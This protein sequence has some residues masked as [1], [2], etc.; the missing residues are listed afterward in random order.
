[1]SVWYEFVDPSTPLLQGDIL[2][3]CPVFF[4]DPKID[5]SKLNDPASVK[6]VV[7]YYDVIVM[8]QSC[9][10]QKAM[11]QQKFNLQIVLCLLSEITEVPI[12]KLSNLRDDKISSLQLL[13]KH[14]PTKKGE[15][16]VEHKVI[17]YNAI[18]TVPL[19]VL[20]NWKNNADRKRPH[21]LP[22]FT[23]LLSQRFALNF[24]KVGYPDNLKPNIEEL[25][26]YHPPKK[27]K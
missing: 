17:D 2:F 18:Y 25:E 22:P 9:E 14:E 4:P 24:M 8:S 12:G 13:N 10:I 7:E 27:V 5:Y 21:L 11:L 23:E 16:K 3:R 19:G 20:N 1:M 15:Y 26:A 6:F